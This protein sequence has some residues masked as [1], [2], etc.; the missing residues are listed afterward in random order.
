VGRERAPVRA[1]IDDN[2]ALRIG[3]FLVS[4]LPAI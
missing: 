1:L 3:H 2:L 4:P